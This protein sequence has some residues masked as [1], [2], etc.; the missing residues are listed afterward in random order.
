MIYE[1]KRRVSIFLR[2]GL[3]LHD[4]RSCVQDFFEGHKWGNGKTFEN[5]KDIQT[6][7]KNGVKLESDFHSNKRKTQVAE[8][9]EE[10]AQ[11]QRQHG[12]NRGIHEVLTDDQDYFRWLLTVVWNWKRDVAPAVPCIEK[13]DSRAKPQ[14][15]A[16]SIDGSAE[17]S[18]SENTR[19]C[20]KVKRYGPHCRKNVCGK[21]TLW[22]G[23]QA[24]LCSRNCEDTRSQSRRG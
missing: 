14:A 20:G 7:Q 11:Q 21:L 8:W 1:L 22:L 6:R 13:D 17:Q 16:T 10:G 19:A 9:A 3:G 5:P 24:N 2:S 12:R 23:T 4:S 18:D 15:I